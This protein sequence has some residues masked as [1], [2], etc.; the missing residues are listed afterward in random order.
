MS[1]HM[2]RDQIHDLHVVS[3]GKESVPVDNVLSD[4]ID[5]DFKSQFLI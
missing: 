5:E 3:H 2:Y 1:F 4:I